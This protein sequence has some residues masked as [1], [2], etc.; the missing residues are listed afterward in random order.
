M[1]HPQNYKFQTMIRPVDATGTTATDI[2][3][4]TRGY[5]YLTVVIQL[6][7]VAANM[8]ALKLQESDSSGASEADF[9]G[10]AFT[11]PTSSDDN[12]FYV[13]LLDLRKRKRYISIVATAGA[14]ATLISAIGILSRAE[15]T[16]TSASERGAAEQIV[17]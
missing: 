9:T 15:V 5:D 6:G 7:N 1:I 12:K 4:D 14:G 16:P 2:E 8:T 10:S 11:S 3:I 17:L 13:A